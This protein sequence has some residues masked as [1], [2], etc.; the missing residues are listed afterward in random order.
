M[1][2]LVFNLKNDVTERF[3]IAL[4]VTCI[5]KLNTNDDFIRQVK[6]SVKSQKRFRKM[7]LFAASTSSKLC[8][9]SI[10]VRK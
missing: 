3:F 8:Y 6:L 1:E 2:F 10:F 5:I 4:P 7:L 9:P